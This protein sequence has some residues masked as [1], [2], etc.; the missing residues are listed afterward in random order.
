MEEERKSSHR[1]RQAIPLCHWNRGVVFTKRK[2]NG[3]MGLNVLCLPFPY[4][5]ASRNPNMITCVAPNCPIS[6][7]G[8]G[9]IA[10]VSL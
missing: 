2:T 9:P 3:L 10:N 8:K 1:A 4:L 7:H 6:K 5:G